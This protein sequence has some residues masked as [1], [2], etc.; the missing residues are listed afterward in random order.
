MRRGCESW[1]RAALIQAAWHLAQ[2]LPSALDPFCPGAGASRA[3]WECSPGS[4]GPEGKPAASGTDQWPRREKR[5]TSLWSV[6]PALAG[7]SQGTLCGRSRAALPSCPIHG[8]LRASHRP[9]N[10]QASTE[11]CCWGNL[12]C[13]AIHAAL[14]AAGQSWACHGATAVSNPLNRHSALQKQSNQQRDI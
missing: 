3:R 4:A 9:W 1:P 6:S 12:A 11:L 10:N 8:P 2:S 13:K 14:E 5:G 7:V